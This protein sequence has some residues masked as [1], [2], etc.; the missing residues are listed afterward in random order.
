MYTLKIILPAVLVVTAFAM[1]HIYVNKEGSG[2]YVAHESKPSPAID[3]ENSMMHDSALPQLPDKYNY[4]KIENVFS[5]RLADTDELFSLEV[6]IA[7]R[8]PTIA[9]D[10]FIESM[11][12][13]EAELIAE[14]TKVVVDM[15]HEELSTV[16]G[17]EILMSEIQEHLN[18]FLEDE[19]FDAGIFEAF[20]TN[21]N[22]V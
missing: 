18:S 14:I 3:P 1:G 8:Q 7:T 15:E 20:I 13:K 17:R 11:R 12:E 21:Y 2:L 4:L 10:F 6:A 22:I 9:S 19:G 16:S 5:G